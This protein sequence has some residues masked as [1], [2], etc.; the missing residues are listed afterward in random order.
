VSTPL[1]FGRRMLIVRIGSLS[2][3]T[4]W[5]TLAVCTAVA[6]LTLVVALIGLGMGSFQVSVPDV[7]RALSG[8][9]PEQIRTVI[10]DWRLSRVVLAVLIGVALG[11]SG[12]IFQS[13]TRNPLGSPD[14]IG[15]SAGAYT[16][17]LIAIIALGTSWTAMVSAGLGGGIVT[18]LAV[19]LLAYKRGVHG[20]RLIVVGIAVT[21]MLGSLNTYLLLHTELWRAQM[22]AVWG[23][24]SI[25]GLDWSEVRIVALALLVVLPPMIGLSR[26]MD[27]LEMGDDAAAALGI[28][29]EPIRVLLVVLGVACV[30]VTSVVAGP[31]AFVALAAPHIARRLTRGTGVELVPSAVVGAA[32]MVVCDQVALH[33]FDPVILPVGLVTVVFGGLYLAWLLARQARKEL[34]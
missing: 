10:V 34:A 8:H 18:A 5:R 33:V 20:F 19:Y 14:V 28:R 30:A 24:G 29:V 7:V 13:L 16:G 21:A 11:L 12:A 27:L 26:R 31:I 17:T 4:P 2:V 1:E 22:A 15:F 9:G 32:L 6:A 3:R 23:A 25:N